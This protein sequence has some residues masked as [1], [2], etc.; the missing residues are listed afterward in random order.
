M[1]QIENLTQFLAERAVVRDRDGD[2]V[3]VFAVKGTFTV[4][5]DGA[6]RPADTPE[7]IVFSPTYFGEPGRSSLQYD[8]DLHLG[9]SATDVIVH[10]LAHA[11][12]GEPTT[13]VEVSLRVDAFVKRLLVIGDRTWVRSPG[14]VELSAPEPFVTMPIVYERAYGG[15]DEGAPD[16]AIDARNPVG[17]GFARAE[18]SLEGRR[19]PNIEDPDAPI[20]AWSDRPMPVGF[21][22]IAREWPTRRKLAGTFDERWEE[23][24]SPLLPDDFDD[25]FHRAAP[26]DQQLA[27]LRGGEQVELV[28]MTPSGFS[29][30]T[31]PRFRVGFRTRIAGRMVRH[32]GTLGTLILEPER[33]RVIVV[34]RSVLPCQDTLYTWRRTKILI[35]ADAP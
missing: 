1:W 16:P 17:V 26:P 15:E 14:G 35:E 7:P 13:R 28:N 8:L 18:G 23:E 32:E 11:P 12:R 34:W 4:D 19:A 25:R 27:P 21:G 5:K 6:T 33:S 10:A 30:F 20:R 29:R 22:P 31:V 24:R 2:E 3:L 9:A